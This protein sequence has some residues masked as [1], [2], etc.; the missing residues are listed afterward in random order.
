MFP[1][2]Y[3]VYTE[4]EDLIDCTI[5]VKLYGIAEARNFALTMQ[6]FEQTCYVWIYKI[7]PYQ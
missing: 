2:T 4:R 7:L 3:P 5:L 6:C 1:N